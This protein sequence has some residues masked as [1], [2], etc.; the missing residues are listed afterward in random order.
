[1]DGCDLA[2]EIFETTDLLG[3][4]GAI[5]RDAP[6]RLRRS[7]GRATVGAAK[8]EQSDARIDRAQQVIHA[9]FPHACQSEAGHLGGKGGCLADSVDGKRS[10]ALQLSAA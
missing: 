7:V 9:G 3:R 5:D 1:M 10:K 6:D 8:M 4:P 2:L